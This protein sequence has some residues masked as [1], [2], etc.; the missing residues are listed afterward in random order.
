MPRKV[1]CLISLLFKKREEHFNCMSAN[2]ILTKLGTL[3]SVK[4]IFEPSVY[5]PHLIPRKEIQGILEKSAVSLRGWSFPHMPRRDDAHSMRP[6]SIGNGIEFY[7]DWED[8]LEFFRFYE[9]GQFLG[10]FVLT[11][12]VIGE[13]RHLPITPGKYLDFLSVIYRITEMILFIKNLVECT[14]IDGGSI[15]IEIDKTMKRELESIFNQRILSF[16]AG[17]VCQMDKVITQVAFTKESLVADHLSISRKLIKDV[18]DDFNWANY[19]EQMIETYQK[20]L[21]NRTL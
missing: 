9:S 6:Y 21:L 19:S 7:T 15:Q 17:Y 4:V 2:K 11:E 5:N 14:N 16:R 3:G 1:L 13:F 18:F 20:N 12:D 8:I 10:R